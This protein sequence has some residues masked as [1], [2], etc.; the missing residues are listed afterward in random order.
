MICSNSPKSVY[1]WY[2]CDWKSDLGNQFDVVNAPK[3]V[4]YGPISHFKIQLAFF[5]K[6]PN[7]SRICWFSVNE[8]HICFPGENLCLLWNMYIFVWWGGLVKHFLFLWYYLQMLQNMH[9]LASKNCLA[10]DVQILPNLY[11]FGICLTEKVIWET[12]FMW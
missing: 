11:I 8:A 1:F 5:V 6:A 7:F 3:Y 4:L 9:I 12:N 10:R 2:L